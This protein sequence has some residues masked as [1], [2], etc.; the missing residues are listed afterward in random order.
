MKNTSILSSG[1]ALIIMG[2]FTLY[3][4]YP[5]TLTILAGILVLIYGIISRTKENNEY[6]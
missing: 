4:G 6:K 3:I 5:G 2:I 1:I